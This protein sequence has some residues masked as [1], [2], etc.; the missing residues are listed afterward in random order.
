MTNSIDP[1]RAADPAA[2]DD[3]AA[4]VEIIAEAI[5]N[6]LA[7]RTGRAPWSWQ[8]EELRDLWRPDAEVALAAIRASGGAVLDAETVTAMRPLVR[9]AE[10]NIE[11]NQMDR[12]S[13]EP[14][15]SLSDEWSRRY[16]ELADEANEIREGLQ[17]S[18]LARIAAALPT[19]EHQP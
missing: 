1:T 7:E 10:L 19:E 18:D 14:S 13:D 3:D 8:V 9:W 17:K 6:R 15:F 5:F 4:L 11:L 2:R 12:E 16:C